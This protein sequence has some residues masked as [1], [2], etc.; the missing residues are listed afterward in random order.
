[1]W[2]E[3]ISTSEMRMVVTTMAA[4]FRGANPAGH[5]YRGANGH[6]F[7]VGECGRPAELARCPACGEGIGGQDHSPTD[8]VTHAGEIEERF[9]GLDLSH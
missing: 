8:G 6:L 4:E 7:T 5:W 3:G 2:K 9:G 1:M